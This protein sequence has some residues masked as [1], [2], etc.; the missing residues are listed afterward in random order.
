MADPT[1]KEMTVPRIS[2]TVE[3][4]SKGKFYGD[5]C[6]D[7]IVELYPMTGR[8]ESLVAGMDPADISE[9]FDILLKR[10]LK[11]PIDPDVMLSTDKFFLV[12]TLRANSYGSHYEFR[13][14]CP[15]CGLYQHRHCEVPTDFEILW[16]KGDH[17]EPFS[18]TLPRS[19]DVVTFRLL[20]GKDEK[21]ILKWRLKELEKETPREGDP[22]YTYRMA[23]H[24]VDINGKAPQHIGEAM[25]YFECL[26]AQDASTFSN[27]IDAQISGVNTELGVECKRCKTRFKTDM[28]FTSGFFRTYTGGAGSSA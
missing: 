26:I 8:E 6:P 3:L 18:V 22:S 25:R 7:G 15:Q 19:K 28:P 2:A 17:A 24:I 27:A 1:P 11:T 21:D 5:I 4:P 13:V 14:R 16:F 20:R 9:T 23:K 10:C 12:L